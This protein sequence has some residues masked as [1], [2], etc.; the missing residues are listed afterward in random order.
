MDVLQISFE[1]TAQ[2]RLFSR[3]D[4]L[5]LL[6]LD[7]FLGLDRLVSKDWIRWFLQD[8]IGLVS[9]L[10]KDGVVLLGLDCFRIR[11]VLGSGHVL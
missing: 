9:G 10:D 11:I 8:W 6:D 7:R 2:R 5:V 1:G 4:I 3:V